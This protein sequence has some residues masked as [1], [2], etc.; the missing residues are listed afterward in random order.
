MVM[1]HRG[2]QAGIVAAGRPRLAPADNSKKREADPG[3]MP[4]RG[5][6][7]PCRRADAGP[8]AAVAQRQEACGLRYRRGG[9][10]SFSC[11]IYANVRFTGCSRNNVAVTAYF[12][13]GYE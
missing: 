12:A 9:R 13:T 8:P 6:P 10:F 7:V 11:A 3:R 2:R 4:G 1:A 5:S